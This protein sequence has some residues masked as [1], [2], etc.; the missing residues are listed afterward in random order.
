M[1]DHLDKTAPRDANWT[2]LQRA[3][4]LFE[5]W[6]LCRTSHC[7]RAGACRGDTRRCC[8]MLVDWSEALS[9]KDKRVDFAEVMERLR[10]ESVQ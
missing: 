8:E 10:N 4:E 7:R 5:L 2:D 9:L 6:R 1:R 3:S